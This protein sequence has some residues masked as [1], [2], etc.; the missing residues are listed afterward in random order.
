MFDDI[1]WIWKYVLVVAL[2][3]IFG[4]ISCLHFQ[5]I[6]DSADKQSGDACGLKWKQAHFKLNRDN[7]INE[8]AAQGC[9]DLKSAYH[10]AMTGSDSLRSVSCIE[11][12]NVFGLYD[13]NGQYIK[14]QH[15][16]ESVKAYLEYDKENKTR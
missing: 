7:L 9:E 15:W 10:D 16:T 13:E 6:S 12:N 2:G 3:Y 1:K 14:Y 5:M 4:V 11:M 8:L